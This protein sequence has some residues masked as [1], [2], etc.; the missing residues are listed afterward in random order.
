LAKRIEATAPPS[1]KKN[2]I[3]VNKA[4]SRQIEKET[5]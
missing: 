4:D 1:K 5:A 2:N 3:A